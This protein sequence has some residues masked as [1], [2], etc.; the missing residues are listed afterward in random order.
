MQQKEQKYQQ[1][2]NKNEEVIAT[3]NIRLVRVKPNNN[4]VPKIVIYPPIKLGVVLELLN[5]ATKYI[6]EQPLGTKDIEDVKD[7]T[8]DKHDNPK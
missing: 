3:I 6:M 1:N 7:I 4:L 2:G 8:E 5:W